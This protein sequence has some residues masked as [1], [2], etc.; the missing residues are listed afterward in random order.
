MLQMVITSSG[1]HR[2]L[3]KNYRVSSGPAYRLCICRSIFLFYDLDYVYWTFQDFYE[4]DTI[5]LFKFLESTKWVGVYGQGGVLT[6]ELIAGW[7]H[8]YLGDPS[9]ARPYFAKARDELKSL[10]SESPDD[11]RLLIS[12]SFASAGLGLSKESIA[13]SDSLIQAFPV[14]RDLL[15]GI[16]M[17]DWRVRVCAAVGRHD[18]AIDIIERILDGPSPWSIK[19]YL[20][21]PRIDPLRNHPRFQALIEK[22][23]KEYGT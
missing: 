1:S 4:R 8:Q 13:Y 5:A 14:E 6:K 15:D 20:I 23:E 22:Y 18:E 3:Q 11:E 12:L 7:A 16:F 21:D 10:R 2:Y 19:D 9:K 17:L